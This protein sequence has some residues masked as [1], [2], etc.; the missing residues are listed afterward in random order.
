MHYLH[1]YSGWLGLILIVG[2]WIPQTLNAIRGK[3][4]KISKVFLWTTCAASVALCVHAWCIRDWPFTILN[5]Y[6]AGNAALGAFL[7]PSARGQ[8]ESAEAQT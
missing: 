8:N 3:P 6:A 1:Q 7:M 5:I 4:G 2:C